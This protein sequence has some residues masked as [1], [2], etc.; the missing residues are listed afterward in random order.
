MELTGS[1]RPRTESGCLSERILLGQ[2][3][4]APRPPRSCR[5]SMP[6][7]RE[8]EYPGPW[9]RVLGCTAA[10]YLAGAVEEWALV[11]PQRMS[12][13]CPSDTSPAPILERL[14][15]SE[16]GRRARFTG[17]DRPCPAFS[18]ESPPWLA[19]LGCLYFAR[20]SES[21]SWAI[22]KVG[23][24]GDSSR[25]SPRVTGNK[26]LPVDGQRWRRSWRAVCWKLDSLP[27]PE[28]RCR[29]RGYRTMPLYARRKAGLYS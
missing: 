23:G 4:M 7:P 20:A 14:S 8:G 10:F 17:G 22:Q 26:N 24:P 1:T 27:P 3:R 29:G 28:T 13:E 6:E 11:V 16:W 21:T 5:A 25:V 2:R 18:S 12:F 19:A 9:H 15:S